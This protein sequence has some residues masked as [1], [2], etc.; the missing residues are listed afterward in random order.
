[1][2]RKQAKPN[3]AIFIYP[4]MVALRL[5]GADLLIYATIYSSEL[6][7]QGWSRLAQ[8]IGLTEAGTIRAVQRMMRN[9]YVE[10]IR[11]GS[12]FKV[13]NC[14]RVIVPDGIQAHYSSWEEVWRDIE[15]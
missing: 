15:L 12:S 7:D 14:F 10:K 6:Y 2:Q 8:T 4:W 13:T 11:Q 1:M 9:G 5:K 3:P